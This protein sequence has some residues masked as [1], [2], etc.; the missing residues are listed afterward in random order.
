MAFEKRISY[1]YV[2]VKC[3]FVS[4]KNKTLIE[5]MLEY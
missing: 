1:R 4:F 3:V 2:S 5:I